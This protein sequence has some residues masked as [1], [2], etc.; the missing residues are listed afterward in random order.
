MFIRKFGH[1]HIPELIYQGEYNMDLIRDV[2]EN[3]YDLKEGVI[4]KGSRKSKGQDL[5]W[6]TKVK[7]N[8]W[9][10]RVKDKLGEIALL[11][12]VNGNRNLLI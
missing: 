9:L 11:E 4:C 8:L 10:E 2:R 3:V 6:M 7:T 12:E 5:V 1:L